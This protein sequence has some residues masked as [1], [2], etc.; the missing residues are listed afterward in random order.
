MQKY[1]PTDYNGAWEVSP[2]Q[3]VSAFNL[4]PTSSSETRNLGGVARVWIAPR[5]GT[6]SIRGHVLKADARAGSGVYAV[7]NHVSGRNV[8]QI[9]PSA[10]GKK[11]VEGTDQAGYST[12]VSN[13]SVFPGDAIRFEVTANGDGANSATSW[14]PSVGYISSAVLKCSGIGD[15]STQT[16][17]RHMNGD[18]RN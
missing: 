14:T 11:L 12:D 13:I 6:I 9:W 15:G 3:Y 2:A 7:I 18:C 8:T 5:R 1:F 10:G 16:G 4:T 17:K